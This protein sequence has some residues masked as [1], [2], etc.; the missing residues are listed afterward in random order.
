MSNSSQSTEGGTSIIIT[1]IINGNRKKR[2]FSICLT[3][4]FLRFNSIYFIETDIV[5]SFLRIVT[6]DHSSNSTIL[7]NLHH[8]IMHPLQ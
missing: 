8:I 1:N 3:S 7:L 4:L 5:K 2:I 6:E